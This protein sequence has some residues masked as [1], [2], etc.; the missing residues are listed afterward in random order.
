[1]MMFLPS[2]WLNR[3]RVDAAPLP[4][5][6]ACQEARVIEPAL[7]SRELAAPLGDLAIRAASVPWD[8]DGWT[9]RERNAGHERIFLRVLHE[10]RREGLDE[11]EPS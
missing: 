4:F 11:L 10:L 3:H 2:A 8:S 1:M 6:G 5:Q 9:E 7:F